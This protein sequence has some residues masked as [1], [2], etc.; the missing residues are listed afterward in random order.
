MILRYTKLIGLPI[1]ELRDQ[2]RLGIVA[3]ILLDQN[4]QKIIGFILEN[5]IFSFQ[6]PKIVL[7][8]DIIETLKEAL[9]V[10]DDDAVVPLSEALPA[11]ELFKKKYFGIAQKVFSETG[12]YLG[13]VTDYIIENK[14]LFI[15]KYYVQSMTR[16]VIIPSGDIIDFNGKKITVRDKTTAIGLEQELPESVTNEATA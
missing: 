4:G 10:K 3:D 16:E 13:R 5:P 2:A 15:T 11:Q 14:T 12:K 6:P 9:I 7:S 8:I 1:F